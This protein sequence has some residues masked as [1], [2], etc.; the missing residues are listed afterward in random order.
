[1]RYTRNEYWTDDNPIYHNSKDCRVY[2]GI[3]SDLNLDQAL[4]L[5]TVQT[6]KDLVHRFANSTAYQ[7]WLKNNQKTIVVEIDNK[8]HYDRLKYDLLYEGRPNLTIDRINIVIGIVVF[9]LY[10]HELSRSFKHLSLYKKED[11][12]MI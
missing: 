9:P 1:M 12:C 8:H 11:L 7:L 4:C 3:R 6:G 10:R 2:V 5:Q